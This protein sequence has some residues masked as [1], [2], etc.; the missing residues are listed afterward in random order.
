MTARTQILEW[1]ER[2]YLPGEH[3]PRALAVA[4]GEPGIA[5][6][7]RF[8]SLLMLA[9]GTLLTGAG[10][11]FFFAYNWNGLPRL[12]RFGMVEA[13]L[14]GACAVVWTKGLTPVGR[15][16]LFFAAL[17]TGALFALI[18]QTYQLGADP[19]QLFALWAV[20][21]LPWGVRRPPA[22]SLAAESCSSPMSHFGLRPWFEGNP[23]WILATFN[24]AAQALWERVSPLPR[25]GPRLIGTAAGI[26][27]TVLILAQIFDHASAVPVVAYLLWL[28]AM[29]VFYTRVRRDLFMV[30]GGLLSAIIA[31]VSI[32]AHQLSWMHAESISS[33]LLLAVLV[34][35]LSGA[36]AKW[37]QW[38]AREDT[39]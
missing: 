31:I 26:T 7:R 38:L 32:G 37:M 24:V 35:V 18:G 39:A 30:A 14:L 34:I 3:V 33:V 11:I 36:A 15:A 13:L 10:V 29:L 9:T 4:G 17:L 8:L 20:L 12:V 16:A 22:R 2:G 5:E 6:W 27:L 1:M 23:T 25:L 28:P 19:W 21:I